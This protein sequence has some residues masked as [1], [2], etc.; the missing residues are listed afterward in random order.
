MIDMSVYFSGEKLYGD[1]FTLDQIEEWFKDEQEGYADLGSKDRENYRYVY[2]KLNIRH[3]YSYLGGRRF[4]H[5]LGIGSAYGDE[6][7][8]I[9]GQLDFVTILDPSDAFS[10]TK[11]INGVPCAYYKPNIDGSMSLKN[12]SF[13]LITSLGVM[14]HIPNVSRVMKECS[15]CLSVDGVMLIREPIVSMGDWTRPR[16]E[17]TKRERGIPLKIFEEI[18]M[19]AG[20]TIKQKAL[21]I[22]SVIPKLTNN[23]NIKI[24]NNSAIVWLDDVLSKVFYWNTLYH[25][26]NIITKIGPTSVY[27]VLEKR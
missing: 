2:H 11:E 7:I 4:K 5:A 26:K 22:F 13:D 19:D 14:H 16:P 15:R 18:I 3:G 12:D 20:F 24:Y 25:R 17:L 9:S 1:D 27:F 23:F 6:F 8:P 21:C 10:G